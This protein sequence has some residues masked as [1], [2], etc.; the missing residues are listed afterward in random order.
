MATA[1]LSISSR[2][3]T[4]GLLCKSLSAWLSSPFSS[5]LLC[6]LWWLLSAHSNFAT[7]ASTLPL[8]SL[9]HWA[10]SRDMWKKGLGNKVKSP[11]QLLGN[12]PWVKAQNPLWDSEDAV[13][14]L[15]VSWAPKWIFTQTCASFS[16]HLDQRPSAK[17]ALDK[18][19]LTEQG[20]TLSNVPGNRT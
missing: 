11:I 15:P 18:Q 10:D 19:Q 8:F 13:Y 7:K 12:Q 17:V 5:P 9:L 16:L 4:A 6:G 14:L 2:V 3:H 20:R 1:M